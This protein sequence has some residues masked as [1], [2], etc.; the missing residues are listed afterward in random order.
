MI[1]ITHAVLIGCQKCFDLNWQ[2]I[3]VC[4][5]KGDKIVIDTLNPPQ[6]VKDK[7]T[8]IKC[9][10]AL[11]NVHITYDS[12]VQSTW[13]GQDKK[14]FK[15]LVAWRFVC[16]HFATNGCEE[17]VRLLDSYKEWHEMLAPD[18]QMPPPTRE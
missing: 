12:L 7:I 17:C 13:C 18:K 9:L 1:M 2:K 3:S 4:R 5:E 11:K 16:P 6:A 8:C 10:T 15:L 14:D